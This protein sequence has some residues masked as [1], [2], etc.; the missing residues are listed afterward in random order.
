M[1]KLILKKS[2]PIKFKRFCNK[3]Y[4]LFNCLG[5]EVIIGTLSVATLSHATAQGMSTLPMK[6]DTLRQAEH[7]ISLQDV[8]VKGSR[9]PISQ[10]R[11]ARMVTVLSRKQIACAPVQSVNDLLKYAVGVDVRQRGALGA[12]TDVSIRGGT[13]EQIAVLLNGINICD[14]Q[15]GHNTFDFPV[16]LNDIERIEVLE[17][18]AGRVY[19]TS[20]LL[21]AVNIVTKMPEAS[22][23]DVHAEAGS[24]G[25]FATGARTNHHQGKWNNSLSANYTRSDGY[26]RSRN[27][28]LNADFNG[29]KAF[30]Q[31]AFDDASVAVSWYAGMSRKAFGANTFYSAKFDEQF[32]QTTK[33]FTA[34]QGENKK[35]F[36]R[37]R[38]SIYWNRSD[39][40]FEL[41]RGSEATVPFNRHRTH[42]TGFSLN[43]YF[44]TPLGRTAVGAEVRHEHIKSTNLGEPRSD[45]SVYKCGLSRTNLGLTVEHNVLLRRFSLSAG[46]VVVKNTW[47]EMD[48]RVFPGID[49]GYR[50]GDNW[51]VF[52][53]YNSSLRLPSFTELYYSVGG[54]KADK[55]LKAEE[56]NAVE[57]GVRYFS[58]N[59]S[60][61][62][63]LFFHRCRN[64]IDWIMDTNAAEPVW[65]SVNYT[66]T[67][68][69]GLQ[70]GLTLRLAGLLPRQTFLE[71][72]SVSYAYVNED[73][74]EREHIQTQSKLEYLRHKL[75]AQLQ[76]RLCRNVELGISYRFQD[77]AG[78]YT[79]LNK[80]THPY[81][82]YSLFDV[83]IAWNKPAYTVYL[84]ANNVFGKS[85]VDFGNVPQPG[86]WVI[87]G[88]KFHLKL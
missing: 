39:D 12:Q 79:D 62:L 52:A 35:G 24:F 59:V 80:V 16:D 37:L 78:T 13:Q 25:Y 51:K 67:N 33:F 57:G 41:I 49:A 73:K 68:T 26:S 6:S 84:E 66:K 82:P 11:A 28:N 55:H 4:A 56:V 36:I 43:S 69:V 86:L 44:D 50:I 7:V 45:H 14:A 76:T 3:G 88:T 20:S 5:K 75:V 23:L 15:T 77:R 21:G 9:A 17:G 53:S 71:S 85:Y 32:E 8:E 42:V 58:E 38:P 81:K 64:M 72:L 34:V 83:R 18:P 31:G 46:V 47:N 30:Y 87:A 27:G 74:K 40:R 61:S 19:G 2:E 54:H 60:G 29:G 70:S 63:S 22:S 48:W 10:S 1:Y 65:E